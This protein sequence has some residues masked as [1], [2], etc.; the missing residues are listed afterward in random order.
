MARYSDGSAGLL[1][2]VANGKLVILNMPV[3]GE[4]QHLASHPIFV[5]FI[6]EL[7]LELLDAD[8]DQASS[9]ALS[10]KPLS[11]R[12]PRQKSQKT[13]KN[14]ADGTS[15]SELKVMRGGITPL[16]L[17]AGLQFHNDASGNILT[18][19]EAGAPDA[20]TIEQN[21]QVVAG[22]TVV[23]PCGTESDLSVLESSVLTGRLAADRTLS[24]VNAKTLDQD[25][26]Q[27][28]E[29]YDYYFCI[30]LGL[31]FAELLLLKFFRT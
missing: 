3:G 8:S 26:D 2:P 1:L 30:A 7:C 12:V 25:L 6:Q 29:K 14:A 13:Q 27:K 18:W 17:N 15:L 4:G 20:Y 21:G 23:P 22:F 16:E 24:V 5:P 28:N 31:L 11:V 9:R 19:T 10:G